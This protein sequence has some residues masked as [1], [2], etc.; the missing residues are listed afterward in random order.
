MAC[1]IQHPHRPALGDQGEDGTRSDVRTQA[2]EERAPVDGSGVQEA[3]D[4]VFLKA[5]VGV[6]VKQPLQVLSQESQKEDQLEEHPVRN[7]LGL[8][9]GS[10]S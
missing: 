1:G 9:H 7:P 5:L 3:V 6:G 8:P 4:G 2:Q 10:G